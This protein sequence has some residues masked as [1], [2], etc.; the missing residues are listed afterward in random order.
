MQ[1]F[2]AKHDGAVRQFTILSE[3]WYADASLKHA[4]RVN[5]E[6]EINMGFYIP[7]DGSTGEFSIKW[8]PLSGRLVP[9]LQ[10]FDDAWSALANFGDVLQK[11]EILDGT[12]PSVAEVV[13]VLKEC[14]VV[15]A[16]QRVSP[17]ASKASSSE[18][19]E[20]K[21]Q[22][23][24]IYQDTFEK[25][26]ELGRAITGDRNWARGVESGET[27]KVVT[28]LPETLYDELKH[29]AGEVRRLRNELRQA[30][31]GNPGLHEKYQHLFEPE[32]N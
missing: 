8:E 25:L 20:A 18:S 2:S 14:G 11:L 10:A 4:Q 19:L 32:G 24:A 16:T 3:S 12:A 26:R 22:V 28:G 13:A 6:D 15:D 1:E 17:Y 21:A 9:Q 27:L 7:G 30:V 23:L 29:T 5:G 31:R